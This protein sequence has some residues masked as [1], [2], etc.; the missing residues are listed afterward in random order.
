MGTRPI[1]Y[2]AEFQGQVRTGPLK[3]Q[4]PLPSC[5]PP[6]PQPAFWPVAPTNDRVK[7]QRAAGNA[8]PVVG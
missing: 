1:P 4:S 7:V 3:H 6:P 8:D 5:A 2:E